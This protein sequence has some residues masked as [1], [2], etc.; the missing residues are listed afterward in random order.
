MPPPTLTK[1]SDRM[2]V[3][4]SRALPSEVAAEL[5]EDCVA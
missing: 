5:A 3:T 1:A 2:G 4:F